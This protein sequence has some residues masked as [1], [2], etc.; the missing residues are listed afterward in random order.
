MLIADHPHRERLRGQEHGLQEPERLLPKL[1]S[2][3]VTFLFTDV[4]GSTT[5]LSELG[6]ERYAEA[7]AQHRAALR[8]AFAQHDG[9]EVDTQGDA[10]FVAFARASDAV[11]A[12]LEGRAALG[13][14]PL[15]V[16]MGIHTGEPIAIGEGYVGVDVHRAARVCAAGHGGQV[17][18]TEATRNL[19]EEVDLRD[20]G[21]RRL[22][23]LSEPQRLYQVGSGEFPPLRTLDATNLP[24]V[25]TSLLDREAEIADLV[26]LLSSG[27]RLVTVTGAG[28]TGKTRLPSRWPPSLRGPSRTESSGCRLATFLIRDLVLPTVAQTLG[29]TGDPR[30]LFA[31]EMRS[32]CSTTRSIFSM[33][34]EMLGELLAAAP[35]LRLLVTSRAPLRLTGEREFPLEPLPDSDA[36]MLFVERARDVGRE[37]SADGTVMAIA[38]AST[39]CR[40][41]WSSPRH[42]RSSSIRRTLLRA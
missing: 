39:A 32:C 1:P 12:A 27:S 11:A 35:R 18:L 2:G 30:L 19:L 7:L 20:L 38:G 33:P 17:L 21:E 6:A 10:F 36:V 8:D 9:V 4:E 15:R 14:G 29:A 25:A 31:I 34:P 41:H 22:K 42:G 26:A 13:T 23:D 37:L 5:L 28:G 16:R 24:V 3:T 40:S